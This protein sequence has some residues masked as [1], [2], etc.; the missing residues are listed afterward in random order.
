MWKEKPIWDSFFNIMAPLTWKNCSLFFFFF[1]IHQK[2]W[3]RKIQRENYYKPG[4]EDWPMCIRMS[5]LFLSSRQLVRTCNDTIKIKKRRWAADSWFLSF[6]SFLN[7]FIF[8]FWSCFI[9]FTKSVQ[10][11][12]VKERLDEVELGRKRLKWWSCLYASSDPHI[13]LNSPNTK[14]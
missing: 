14:S 13:F 11:S 5:Q 3:I 7:F 8:I 12:G 6:L 1:S 9:Y 4:T 2:L 10:H